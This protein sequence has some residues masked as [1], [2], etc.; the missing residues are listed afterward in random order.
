MGASHCHKRNEIDCLTAIAEKNFLF[1]AEMH[2]FVNYGSTCTTFHFRRARNAAFPFLF[3]TDPLF[4]FLLLTSAFTKLIPFL[5]F[6][7]VLMHPNALVQIPDLRAH[8]HTQTDRCF[9][10]VSSCNCQIG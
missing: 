7:V 4:S 10:H 3:L 5:A 8:K 9:F 6:H 1:S 2:V